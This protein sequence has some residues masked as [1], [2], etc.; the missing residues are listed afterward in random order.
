MSSQRLIRHETKTR[1]VAVALIRCGLIWLLVALAARPACAENRVLQLDGEGDYVQLPSDA[2][3]HLA[4]ATVESWVKWEV[5]GRYSQPWG[6][7][8]GRM[9]DVIYL[10]NRSHSNMLQFS[11]YE[12]EQLHTIAVPS[13]L[14][15]GEW[16]HVAAVSGRGGMCL[17]LNGV[18]IGQDE[19]EGSFAKLLPGADSHFG[20]AHWRGNADF[21][22][23]MD[24][25][26]IWD[27]ARTAEEINA[28][29][30]TSL[31][32]KEAHLVGLWNFDSGDAADATGHG[33]D[34]A[35]HGDARCVQA[36]LPTANEL[37]RP[38]V[39]FGK[40]ASEAGEPLGSASVILEQAAHA[41]AATETDQSGHYQIVFYPGVGACD[42]AAT[43]AD[44][45]ARQ[46]GVTIAPG[47]RYEINLRLGSA[48]SLAGTLTAYDGSPHAA[49]TVEAVPVT[50]SG[51][52]AKRLAALSDENGRFQFANLEAGPYEV[53]AYLGD[54]YAYYGATVDAETLEQ[55]GATLQVQPGQPIENI[56]VHFAPFKK[57]VWRSYTYLDGLASNHVTAIASDALGR[58]WFG[59]EAGLSVFDGRSFATFTSQ[60]GLSSN[61]ITTV[62]R[63]SED[64][65]W[66]GT[67]NGLSRYDGTSFTAFTV[68][69]GLASE[70]IY[71]VY[72]DKQG[73]L[74][75]GTKGGVSRYAGH[76]FEVFTQDGALPS[77]AV[78]AIAEDGD[79][80]LWF[81][82]DAGLTRYDGRHFHT[83][84]VEEGLAG[85]SIRALCRDR[86][87]VLWIGTSR[88]LSR[89]EGET[90][91]S[92]TSAD[93]LADNIINAIEEDTDGRLWLATE[94]GV[95]LFDGVGFVTFVPQD[96]L[97]HW[98]VGAVHQ[99]ARGAI[100]SVRFW[101]G[102]RVTMT[103]LWSV[104][105]CGTA[106]LATLYGQSRKSR[107]GLCGWEP[108]V[109]LRAVRSIE[110]RTMPA[111]KTCRT[112][113]SGAVAVRRT[114]C[115][116]SA[117]LPVVYA[118]MTDTLAR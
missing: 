57:G 101:A 105:R 1:A 81:G 91:V 13:I 45:G 108:T 74:W 111:E 2:F 25:I 54:T 4:E 87:G 22:G 14:E 96:G 84:T 63:D 47:Q 15:R 44:D 28:T 73:G 61:A 55:A 114:E 90:F 97:A 71:A 94:R 110:S 102:P 99:D 82:T 58:I 20:K 39:V 10:S 53:R 34:G 80:N 76:G 24:E 12:K 69:D 95:S 49:V 85:N 33:F 3:R 17:Y 65:L 21:H 104:L 59:T 23:Q 68:Q 51:L 93:G 6:F 41:I 26:R 60:D 27:V 116:G 103:A 115:S 40:I 98:R 112:V 9:W 52:R 117:P 88:G 37:A 62:Y 70:I 31:T 29:M 100:G 89:Y 7:G 64:I 8:S 48:I 75:I 46:L 5:F 38:A 107:T 113:R 67:M 30:F 50:H 66:I 43:W 77:P 109:A 36:E 118:D 106:C 35:Y 79:G 11:I 42:I 18:L 86:K 16:C 19:Y 92:F 72:E 78:T 32:G 83:F 56:D